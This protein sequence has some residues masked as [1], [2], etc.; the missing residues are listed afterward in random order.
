MVAMQT[1]AHGG[2]EAEIAAWVV[3]GRVYKDVGVERYWA[4]QKK[5]R[6]KRKKLKRWRHLEENWAKASLLKKR[7]LRS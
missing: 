3:E 7:V 1:V 4:L 6:R 5:M 2:A